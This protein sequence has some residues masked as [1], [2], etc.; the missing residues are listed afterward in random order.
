MTE[1]KIFLTPETERLY[2]V[3]I[4]KFPPNS[5]MEYKGELY[6]LQGYCYEGDVGK[7]KFVGVIFSKFNPRTEFDSFI[8]DEGMFVPLSDF[9]D[10]TVTKALVC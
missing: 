2:K 10:G 7:E 1:V 9:E 3:Q 5:R 8:D 4:D 6:Y